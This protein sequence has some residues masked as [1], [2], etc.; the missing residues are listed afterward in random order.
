LPVHSQS[1]KEGGHVFSFKESEQGSPIFTGHDEGHITLN[2]AEAD[3]P[4][5]ERLREQFG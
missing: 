3:N 4:G 2:I 5:R 1:E